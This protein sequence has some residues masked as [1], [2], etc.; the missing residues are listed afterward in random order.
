MSRSEWEFG[1]VKIPS[2]SWGAFKKSLQEAHNQERASAFK[3]AESIQRELETA[4]K[5]KKNVAYQDVVHFV[6]SYADNADCFMAV[7]IVLDSLKK[8]GYKTKK[9]TQK[10]LEEH[11]PKANT[12]TTVFGD[13]DLYNL[14]LN[15][16]TKTVFWD[17]PDGNR[18]VDHARSTKLG[19]VLLKTLSAIDYGSRNDSGGFFVGNDEINRDDGDGM[20]YVTAR[21]GKKGELYKF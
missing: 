6:Q 19:R 17:V 3:Y 8:D 10:M 12:K 16:E 4:F 2:K 1:S 9:I 21:Y 13:D 11:S 7:A 15:N 14:S 18:A 20:N 5:G